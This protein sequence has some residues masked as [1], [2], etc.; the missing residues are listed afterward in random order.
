MHR[1]LRILPLIA[2][3]A[4]GCAG[5]VKVDEIE[6]FGLVTSAL[7]IHLEDGKAEGHSFI[8][9]NQSGLC[10][11]LTSY[12]EAVAEFNDAVEDADMDSF[13]ED[14]EEPYQD[15]ADASST[16]NNEG[17]RY[18]TFSVNDDGES[19][20]NEDSYDVGD[21]PGVNGGV[22]YYEGDP[23]SD[24]LED[25]DPDADLADNCGMDTEYD[26][27]D[28]YE[29]WAFDD[30][31]LEITGVSDED[32]VKGDLEVDLITADEDGDDAGTLVAGFTASYC[33]IEL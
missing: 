29:A 19:E 2:L 16:I 25:Y 1:F 21:D 15:F 28:Y 22:T 10:D 20:P 9:A 30:G 12:Y 26:A 31:S 3:I 5:S 17:A 13:C 14:M 4:P 8:L 11:S 6:G 18:V 27:E 32:S 24:L 7:W 23:T 33:H